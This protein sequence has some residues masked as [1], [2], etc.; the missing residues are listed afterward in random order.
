MQQAEWQEEAQ[1]DIQGLSADV[2]VPSHQSSDA[3]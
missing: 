3:S 2:C 1:E